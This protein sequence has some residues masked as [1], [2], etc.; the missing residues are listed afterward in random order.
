MSPKFQF[1]Y[2]LYKHLQANTANI[3]AECRKAGEEMGITAE[4]KNNIGATGAISGCHGLLMTEVSE[5]M[6]KYSRRVVHS[7]VLDEELREVVK[8]VY[9]DEYDAALT[10]TCE[11][12][13]VICY[14]VLYA[15]PMAG[16]G[17][18][19]R[20]RYLAP[21]ERHM[22][23]Q[24]A[25]GRPFPP[26]YK[27][28]NAERGE[29]AGELGVTG[30]RQTNLETVYVRL[31]GG[32]Y[33]LHG[34]KHNPVQNLLHVDA[35][36]SIKRFTELSERHQELLV[37]YA[38]LAYDTPGYGYGDKASNGA[39]ELQVGLGELAKKYDVP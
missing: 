26:K 37:G 5:A 38:S 12:G 15:P 2:Q 28:V 39:P 9:G 19:Y 4:M 25:Y 1:R 24:G 18:N 34:I 17:E 10:N 20:G 3:Y 33:S 6:E 23:H 29:A 8:S 27:E 16:R 35:K 31:D 32:D 22:H 30:K 14:D 7:M 13:L 21:Y 36:E 11:G